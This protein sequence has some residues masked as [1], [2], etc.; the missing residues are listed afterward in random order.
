M[1]TIA[2]QVTD[3]QNTRGAKAARMEAIAQKSIDEG[4]SMDERESEEFDGIESEIQSIDSDLVRLGKLDKLMKSAKPVETPRVDKDPQRTAGELRERGPTI[5]VAK[6][7]DEKF[8]GQNYTRMVIAR[9]FAHLNLVSGNGGPTNP[10]AIA[11]QRWGKTNPTLVEV[12]KANEV[13]GGGAGSGEWGAELVQADTRFTGDFIE[14]LN[15]RTVFNMLPLREVPANIAIKGQDG[16]ATGY[17]VGESK[18]IPVSKADFSTVNL[19][20]LKVAALAVVS[21]ELLRDSTP[22]AE[23]LVRDALVEAAAQ[24]IDLTFLSTTAVSAGV[25]PAGLLASPLSALSSSGNDEGS[26]L[27]DIAALYAPFIAAKN[28]TGLYFVMNP[29]LA[30][31]LQLMRNALDQKSFPDIRQTGG[32]LEGDPVVTG[33]NVNASHIILLKPS[34]IWKIGDGGVEI[35]MSRDA[36]IEQ[37]SVPTGATDTPVGASTAWTNMFQAESTAIKVVRSMNFAKRRTHAAQYI[38]DAAYGAQ[39]S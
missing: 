24:R 25:S 6:D 27:T 33:D 19:T 36:S 21:N 15:S 18:P 14:Y 30:K 23:G 7:R 16:A 35:S 26:V 32:T 9:A 8:K 1:K 11:Q 38:D 31:A 12:I 2:S 20:P 29:A 3:L 5:I 34:D 13:A 37:N 22:A 4:R 39:A 10:V 17:W 28:A